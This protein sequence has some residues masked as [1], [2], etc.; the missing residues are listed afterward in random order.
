MEDC[1]RR[2]LPR[3]MRTSWGNYYLWDFVNMHATYPLCRWARSELAMR[4]TRP[5]SRMGS[6]GGG[7][8]AGVALIL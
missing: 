5:I 3:H 1:V 8:G 4:A 2:C 6:C 7:P